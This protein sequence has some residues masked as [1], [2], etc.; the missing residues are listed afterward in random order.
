MP[1]RRRR[2]APKSYDWL[3]QAW[4]ALHAESIPRLVGTFLLILL[5]S[6]LGILYLEREANAQQFQTVED[7]LWWALVTLTT[8]GYG[9]KF[10]ITHAGRILAFFV[11]LVGIGLVGTVTAKIASVLVERRIKEGRGLSEARQKKGHFVILGWK[12]DLAGLVADLILSDADLEAEDIVLVNGAGEG[13]NEEIRSRFPRIGYIHGDVVDS[14][15]LRRAHVQDAAKLL[16]LADE[17]GGRT[18]QEIDARTVMAVMNVEHLAPEVYTCAEVLDSKY[19]EHLRLAHCDEIVLSREH[20][21]ALLVGSAVSSG[22]SG[23]VRSLLQG[24][25][26][27]GL[28]VVP[29]PEELVGKTFGEVARHLREGQRC[30]AIGLLE[31]TGRALTIKREALRVAQKTDQVSELLDNLQKV[32]SLE[33]NRPVLNPPD[34]YEVGRRSMVIVVGGLPSAEEVAR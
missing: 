19:V 16:V 21:R 15:T 23:V 27:Q 28:G 1:S 2:S 14:E 4:S 25:R 6:G 29:V 11:V 24:Q 9:D 8:I 32:K 34:D 26:Q 33:T 17:V 10:P 31:N 5:L 12:A 18:D 20:E 22:L 30:L 13:M 7:G 3:K